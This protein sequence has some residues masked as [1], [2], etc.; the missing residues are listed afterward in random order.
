MG[1]VE[2]FLMVSSVGLKVE[3][4]VASGRAPSAFLDV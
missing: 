3:G 2:A 4:I 1:P